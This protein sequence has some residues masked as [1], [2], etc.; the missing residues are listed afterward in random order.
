M[1]A[2]HQ[3]AVLAEVSLNSPVISPGGGRDHPKLGD[4]LSRSS[5]LTQPVKGTGCPFMA[6]GPRPPAGWGSGSFPPAT[7]SL[8]VSEESQAGADLSGR[9]GLNQQAP[10]GGQAPGLWPTFEKQVRLRVIQNTSQPCWPQSRPLGSPGP[11]AQ[12]PLLLNGAQAKLT[13]S[14]VCLW[15][16]SLAAVLQVGG[17]LLSSPSRHLPRRGSFRTGASSWGR[18]EGARG[19]QEASR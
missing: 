12:R 13:V 11:K 6:S 9:E 1:V 17:R 5:R 8:H 15:V 7:T 3:A 4:W 18:R 2:G 16:P 14:P 10:W 19:V